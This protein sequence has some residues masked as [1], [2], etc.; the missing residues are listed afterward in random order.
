MMHKR[1]VQIGNSRGFV[2]R[3][4]AANERSNNMA[5]PQTEHSVA[6]TAARLLVKSLISA[7]LF[8]GP[9]VC[10]RAQ[11]AP[12]N[13][14][15]ESWTATT[16]TSMENA[17][18]SRTAESH[19]RSGNR[20]VDKQRVEVLGPNG[21]YQPDRETE[22]ET[23]QVSATTTRT[24]ERTYGW[25]V[26]GHRYLLQEK[27][28]EA[29]SSTSGDAH[30]VRTT[31][32]SDANGNL[33]VV[34]REVA[35]TAKT[36]PSEQETKTTVYLADGNGGWTPSYRTQELKKGS[37]DQ[38][39]ELKKTMLRPD[40]NGNWE[41]GEVKESTIMEDSKNR[42]TEERVLRP[43]SEG[44]LSEVSRSVG[45]ETETVGGERINSVEKYSTDVPGLAI[46]GS[47]RLSQRV[48][49]IQT[50]DS[51]G[52][53]TEQQV[54]QPNPG[55]PNAS[56]PVNTK[57]KYI[58]QYGFNGTQRTKTTQVRDINGNFNVISVETGK[59]DKTPAAQAQTAPSDKPQY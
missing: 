49:T 1:E 42:T 43:D 37:V 16:Q 15:D 55:G 23:V 47:L 57:A 58:V 59:S 20:S 41:V 24:V 56:L 53:T 29:R 30:V 18:P 11:D 25:D 5:F 40:S 34:Q 52:K 10:T 44:R 50:K 27:E 19:T 35:D 7:I 32:N 3:D 46:D 6:V 45:K 12:P 17:N 28:E 26:N 48:T 4:T 21:R 8:V 14:T 33:H 2:L 31:S 54:E 51:G 13:N 39:V 36:S 38:R 22:K 9:A